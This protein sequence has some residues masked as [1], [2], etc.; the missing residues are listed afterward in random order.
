MKFKIIVK[1][2]K[3]LNNNVKRLSQQ[4]LSEQAFLCY[5]ICGLILNAEKVESENKALVKYITHRFADFIKYTKLLLMT[6][7]DKNNKT[8]EYMLQSIMKF[9]DRITADKSILGDYFNNGQIDW[10]Y[11]KEL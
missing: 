10:N 9:E 1:D 3:D 4:E 8:A 2:S 6:W 7:F 11:I 5:S